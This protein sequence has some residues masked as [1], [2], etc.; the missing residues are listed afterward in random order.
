MPEVNFDWV[1]QQMTS[2]GVRQGTG[3]AVLALLETWSGL[4]VEEHLHEDVADVLADLMQSKALIS[5]PGTELWIQTESG[6]SLR[7]GDTVRVH[8]DAFKGSEG[9]IHNGRRGKVVAIRSGSV[10]VTSTDDLKPRLD[11]THYPFTVL[12]KLYKI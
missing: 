11:G 5:N 12:D 2:A 9:V 8:V 4:D 1:K 10:V 3:D 6:G 7:V